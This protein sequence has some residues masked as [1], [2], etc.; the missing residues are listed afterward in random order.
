[1]LQQVVHIVTTWLQTVNM[2]PANVWYSINALELD[3]RGVCFSGRLEQ[4]SCLSIFM[5]FLSSSRQIPGCYLCWA[6]AGLFRM[7]SHSTF[8]TLSSS[9]VHTE[10]V[11]A[12]DN[13]AQSIDP[14]GVTVGCIELVQGR[15]HTFLRVI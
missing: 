3:S 12:P 14:S 8:V 7:P 4:L 13:S 9:A 11:T 10:L 15:V 2:E 1:M 6:M 5:G